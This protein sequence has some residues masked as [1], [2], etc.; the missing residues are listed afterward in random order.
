M[1]IDIRNDSHSPL[2]FSDSRTYDFEWFL[3]LE[4]QRSLRL[5]GSVCVLHIDCTRL[6]EVCVEEDGTPPFG[7]LLREVEETIKTRTRRSDLF[8]PYEQRMKLILSN[9]SKQGA[10]AASQRIITTIHNSL[11]PVV[12]AR[13][14]APVD[15]QIDSWDFNG[16]KNYERLDFKL[17]R[18]EQSEEKAAADSETIEPII[19]VNATSR[20]RAFTYQIKR[21][22]DFTGAVFGLFFLCPVMLLIAAVIKLTSSGPVF[23]TQERVGKNGKVFKFIKFRSMYVNVND[24]A[25]REYVTKLIKGQITNEK[26]ASD[27]ALFKLEN[28][29]RITRIGRILRKYS[30]DELPQLI[31][32]LKG[33]MSLVGPRPAIPY[34]VNNYSYWHMQR[35]NALPGITGLWQVNG[36]SRT[37]FSEMVRYDIQYISDW[38]LWLDIK[39]LFRTIPAVL[40]SDGAL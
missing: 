8:F 16:E 26:T 31:N 11:E 36:R 21:A 29:D 30:L 12:N 5:E 34:E 14:A 22:I 40:S 17:I 25:H 28:D 33:E 13:T 18:K 10:F 19:E 15:V 2:R 38:S 9:T 39:I 1:I 27:K 32:V 23:F 37:T 6:S 7:K 24:E 35:F 3:E 4:K 20:W